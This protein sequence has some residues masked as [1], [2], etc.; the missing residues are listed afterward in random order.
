MMAV[1]SIMMLL[2]VCQND[3]KQKTDDVV[4]EENNIQV[5][6]SEVDTEAHTEASKEDNALIDNEVPKADDTDE[7]DEYFQDADISLLGDVSIEE[8]IFWSENLEGYVRFLPAYESIESLSP[9]E[10]QDTAFICAM[11]YRERFNIE[12]YSSEEDIYEAIEKQKN[13]P[14]FMFTYLIEVKLRDKNDLN[15]GYVVSQKLCN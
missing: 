4:T 11:T 7:V 5:T 2:A 14:K 12:S 9:I 3:L 10:K 15:S 13:Q 1:I 8:K 6:D